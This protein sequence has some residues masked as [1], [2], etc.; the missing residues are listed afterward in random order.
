MIAK[1]REYDYAEVCANEQRL[2][3][4]SYTFDDMTVVR[5][6]KQIVP[7]YIS[8]ESKYCELDKERNS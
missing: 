6:M 3:E 1:V 2:L 4:A 5:L 7:E 8:Q